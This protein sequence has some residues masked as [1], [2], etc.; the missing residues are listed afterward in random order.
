MQGIYDMA[1]LVTVLGE[2][3]DK[4]PALNEIYTSLK[5]GGILSITEIIF[6]PHFQSRK[7]VLHLANRVGFKEKNFF[8]WQL[9][10]TIHL[11]K[12]AGR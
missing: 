3:P 7:K 12:P 9:A 6:D 5:P 11:E 4:I 1:L 2:I 8:G 10:Y